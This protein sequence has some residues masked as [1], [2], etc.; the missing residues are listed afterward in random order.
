MLGP[1]PPQATGAFAIMLERGI[2]RSRTEGISDPRVIE[3]LVLLGEQM[4]A[5]QKVGAQVKVS[6]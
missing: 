2:N 3:P 5:A 1:V 6:Y 4:R